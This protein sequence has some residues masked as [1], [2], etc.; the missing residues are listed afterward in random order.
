VTLNSTRLAEDNATTPPTTTRCLILLVE[1]DDLVRGMVRTLFERHLYRV[2][3][4]ENGP[5]AL[6]RMSDEVTVIVTD[7]RMPGMTGPELLG[8]LRQH[9]PT[10]P[11]VLM[12]GYVGDAVLD[13]LTD[14]P[15]A[16]VKKPFVALD[17][18]L[19]ALNH[20]LRKPSETDTELDMEI[21]I[22]TIMPPD[23]DD[24]SER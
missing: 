15:T 23:R 16:F 17:H 11:A 8:L 24:A 7:V 9:R 6:E 12:S 19:N 4:A 18:L 14:A 21:N 20:V 5:T 1:D 13:I 3:E 10:L 22:D 2:I